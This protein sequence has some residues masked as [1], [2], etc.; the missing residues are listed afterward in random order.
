MACTG[1]TKKQC[2]VVLNVFKVINEDTKMKT[3]M[4]TPDYHFNFIFQTF[5]SQ[6]FQ[7]VP[8]WNK[9]PAKLHLIFFLNLKLLNT[10]PLLPPYCEYNK[11]IGL[12]FLVNR[13][14]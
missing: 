8:M 13:C 12:T 4:I 10:T 3:S 5:K 2:T 14:P 11:K 6:F 7:I 9:V 1:L